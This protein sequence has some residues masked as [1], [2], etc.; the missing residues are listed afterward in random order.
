M[1]MSNFCRVSSYFAQIDAMQW[2]P[3]MEECLG[4]LSQ[5]GE[6]PYDE[7][8]AHQ[9]W[10]QR[11]A[12][13]VESARGTTT[14]PPAFYLAALQH[15]VDQVKGQISPQLQQDGEFEQSLFFSDAEYETF[16]T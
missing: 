5:N 8:F 11:I 2:T 14:V 13:E 3:Y 12:G 16:I 4:V 1:I 6:C 9:V 15:K 10:L 7:M